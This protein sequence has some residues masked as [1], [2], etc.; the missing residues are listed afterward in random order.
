MKLATF[1]VYPVFGGEWKAHF[2][3]HTKQAEPVA[4]RKES[5]ILLRPDLEKQRRGLGS[6]LL[7]GLATLLTLSARATCETG[8]KGTSI[9]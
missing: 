2:L 5:F 4:S 6:G 3:D 7:G 8:F 1:Q 9:M